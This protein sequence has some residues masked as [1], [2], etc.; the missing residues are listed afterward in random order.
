MPRYLPILTPF[1]NRLLI[2]FCF[3]LGAPELPK[4]LKFHWRLGFIVFG[5]IKILTYLRCILG[6][7][8]VPTRLHFGPQNLQHPPKNRSRDASNFWSIFT[9]IFDRFLVVLGSQL[10]AMLATFSFKRGGRCER[11][12]SFLMVLCYLSILEPSWPHLFAVWARFWKVWAS[13]LEVFDLHF[14]GFWS[15]FGSHVLYNFGTYF[16]K[17]LFFKVSTGSLRGELVRLREA[18]RICSTSWR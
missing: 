17:L 14:G 11:P 1:L 16:Q 2:D 6:P 5:A 13:I 9:L 8:W 3:Q 18:Q 12:P 7:L 10:G 15:R 4:S